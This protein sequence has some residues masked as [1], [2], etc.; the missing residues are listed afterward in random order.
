MRRAV[1]EHGTNSWLPPAQ[2]FPLPAVLLRADPAAYP[3]F[4]T[5]GA[6]RS[7]AMPYRRTAPAP[8]C[9]RFRDF[10]LP[11][12]FSGADPAAYPRLH[13]GGAL[14]SC[15]VPRLRRLQ[16]R[17]DPPARALPACLPGCSGTRRV[18]LRLDAGSRRAVS[19][20][21]A[22][23]GG[24]TLCS[25][26]T[27]CSSTAFFGTSRRKSCRAPPEPPKAPAVPSPEPG[28]YCRCAPACQKLRG[29]YILQNDA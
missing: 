18:I 9:H 8:G 24:T 4:H 17:P 5:R 20:D 1:P 15:A 7:C 14:R 3:R 22:A 25:G 2:G 26:S 13:T 23:A 19:G 11:A 29:I 16:P 28:G 21:T 10:P 6:L 12:D 27:L